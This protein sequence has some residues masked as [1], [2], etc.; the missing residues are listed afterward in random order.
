M[1]IVENY[2]IKVEIHSQGCN[3]QNLINKAVS[4]GDS[5]TAQALLKIL[6]SKK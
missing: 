1:S 4:N 6:N 2:I 5:E 3:L